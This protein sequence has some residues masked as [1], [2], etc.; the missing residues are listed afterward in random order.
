[1]CGVRCS[2]SPQSRAKVI[3]PVQQA[4]ACSGGPA[5]RIDTA[6]VATK[7]AVLKLLLQEGLEMEILSYK[8]YLEEPCGCAL[9]SNAINRVIKQVGLEDDRAASLNYS[10][11]RSRS[12]RSCGQASQKFGL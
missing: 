5:P 10:D 2:G 7:D 11:R 12:V 9:I 8:I 4:R 3:H 6:A 1:M